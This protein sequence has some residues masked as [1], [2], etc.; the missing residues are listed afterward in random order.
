MIEV[1]AYMKQYANNVKVKKEIIQFSLRCNC[2]CDSFRLIRNNYTDDENKQIEESNRINDKKVGWHTIY[3][4]LDKDGKPYS[5]IKILGIFKKY[6]EWEPL[7][8]CANIK[9]V[10]AICVS[11]GKEI[12]V[13]DNRLHGCD[14]IDVTKEALEYIP[15]FDGNSKKKE[16]KVS[17][18]IEQSEENNDSNLFSNIMIYEVRNE[19]KIYFEMETG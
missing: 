2:G 12:I 7:P 9:V 14:S 6:F 15:H 19:K 10:K 17:I 4:G 11:C 5:Y 18:E 13:F 3:G 16:C 8:L 1:P